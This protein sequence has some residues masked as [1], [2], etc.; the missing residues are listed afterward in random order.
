M[1]RDHVY[2]PHERP[3]VEVLVDGRWLPGEI[4]MWS[5]LEDDTVVG[6]VQYSTHPGDNRLGT[7]D[8]ADVRPV[9]ERSGE[10]RDRATVWPWTRTQ[11]PTDSSDPA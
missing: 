5:L 3:L 6:N 4:R 7:F 9:D 10:P 8:L 11:K 1:R 2:K